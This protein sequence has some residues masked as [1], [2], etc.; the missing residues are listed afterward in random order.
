MK[1]KDLKVG[2]NIII[3]KQPPQWSSV[4]HYRCPMSRGDITFPYHCKIT[5]IKYDRATKHY[6][7]TEG[8]YGWSLTSLIKNNC[9]EIGLKEQR[10]KKLNML[11]S[12]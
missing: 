9:I 10:R 1:I 4:C 8:E 2:D 6:G 11:K 5:L 7:M 12:K 3:T